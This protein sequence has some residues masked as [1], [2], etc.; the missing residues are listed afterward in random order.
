LNL[1]ESRTWYSSDAIIM[2]EIR[3]ASNSVMQDQ[4]YFT[5][6]SEYVG[7]GA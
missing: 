4:A 1:S 3:L 2:I 5:L 7:D 6:T